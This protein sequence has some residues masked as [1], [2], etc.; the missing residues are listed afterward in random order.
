[1]K[2][3]DLIEISGFN[4]GDRIQ[5]RYQVTILDSVIQSKTKKRKPENSRLPRGAPFS[6]KLFTKNAKKFTGE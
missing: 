6:T 5:P 4:N 3:S 1:M 2:Y